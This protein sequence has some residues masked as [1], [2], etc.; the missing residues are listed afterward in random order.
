MARI[1]VIDAA[2]APD[3]LDLAAQ[4]FAA[5]ST[6]HRALGIKSPEYKDLLRDSFLHNIQQGLSVTARDKTGVL[7]CVIACDLLDQGSGPSDPR[8]APMQDLLHELEEKYIEVQSPKR[9]DAVL[10]DMAF[11]RPDEAGTG[12]YKRLRAASQDRARTKG[13][14]HVI[15]LLSS[16]ATQHV[17]ATCLGH[18]VL[19]RIAFANFRCG[20]TFPFA[21]ITN[22]PEI[23]LTEG[24]LTP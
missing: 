2:S 22:P 4:V 3:C 13:Y 19:A 6:L 9:G 1:D 16:A 24:Q 18:R 11:V 17:V 8:L 23:W 7:G 14:T 5:G 10:I 21:A 15:G 20:D 12:L